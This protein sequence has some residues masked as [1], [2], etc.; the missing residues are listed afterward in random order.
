MVGGEWEGC[1][2]GRRCGGMC[3]QSV[4]RVF[5]GLRGSVGGVCRL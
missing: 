4:K 2:H 3:E 1:V 5:T